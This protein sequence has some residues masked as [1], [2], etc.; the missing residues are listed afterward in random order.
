ML[1]RMDHTEYPKSLRSKSE[2]MLRYIIQD[3]KAAIAANPENPNCD[4]Y[5]DE[6]IYCATE[7]HR[8]RR[9]S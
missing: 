6:V 4:Y 1:K 8:R 7:L 9:S 3:A 2:A 5:L